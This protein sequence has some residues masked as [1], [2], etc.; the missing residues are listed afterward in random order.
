[1]SVETHSRGAE[2]AS[3]VAGPQGGSPVGQVVD[4]VSLE[5]QEQI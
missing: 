5:V 1:M 2:S 3:H 4:A